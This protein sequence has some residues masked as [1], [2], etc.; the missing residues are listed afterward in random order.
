MVGTAFQN[1]AG[2]PYTPTVTAVSGSLTTVGAV[3]CRFKLNGKWLF[4]SGSVAITNIGTGTG[5]LNITFP[6]G[7]TAN[8]P[9]VIAAREGTLS[10]NILYGYAPANANGITVYTAAAAFPVANGG[11]VVFSGWFEIN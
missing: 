4:I 10:G 6:N 11:S 7:Y 2:Q 3:S 8:G 9:Q 1:G 5:G